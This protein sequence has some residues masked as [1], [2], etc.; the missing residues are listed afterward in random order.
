MQY[1]VYYEP[2]VLRFVSA[3]NG[4]HR[5]PEISSGEPGAG[6][7]W[8]FFLKWAGDPHSGDTTLSSQNPSRTLR[9]FASSFELVEAAGGLVTCP[10]GEILMIFRHGLWD[11]PK[12]KVDDG[13]SLERAAVREVTE[14]CGIVGLLVERPL[15]ESFHVYQAKGE[16]WILKKTLWYHMEVKH[17]QQPSPALDEHITR[18][19]WVHPSRMEALL[20]K[21]YR[22]VADLVRLYIN[23]SI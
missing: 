16:R 7:L 1:S 15:T 19:E 10:T 8:D 2:R 17:K 21:S 20:E 18:A 3:E 6:A 5:S 12:G 14:E 11:L 13:E 4:T 23:L 9:A 22:S